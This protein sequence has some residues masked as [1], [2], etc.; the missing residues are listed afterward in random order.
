[1]HILICIRMLTPGM[2]AIYMD[3]MNGCNVTELLY[4]LDLQKPSLMAQE[5]KSNL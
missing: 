2:A 5:L 3:E 4:I 1:M